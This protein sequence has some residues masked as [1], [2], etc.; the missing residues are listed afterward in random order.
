MVSRYAPS[1]AVA[2]T[3]IL[4]GAAKPFS[5]CTVSVKLTG[6]P[7]RAVTVVGVTLMENVRGPLLVPM[8]L[9]RP[10]SLMLGSETGRSALEREVRPRLGG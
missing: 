6:S 3:S 10:V 9:S 4:T 7:G 5:G 1:R 2:E 8:P